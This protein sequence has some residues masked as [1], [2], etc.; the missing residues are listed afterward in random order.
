[1][2]GKRRRI[3]C[4]VEVRQVE[5]DA[6]MLRLRHLRGDGARDV[7]ARGEL[8]QGVIIGHEPQAGP[9]AEIGPLAPERLGQEVAGRAGDVEHR[10]VELH[11]FHVAELGPG[12]VGQR[13]AVGGGDRRVRGFA[14]EVP[15]PAGRE[16]DGARPDQR[17][18]PAPVPDQGAPAS[19][20][21]RE[22][23]DREAVLPDPGIGPGAGLLDH[24]AHHLAAGGVAQGV[25]DPGVRVPPFER[26][27]DLAVHLI[28]VRPPLD[29]LGDPP[30]R[31]ADDHGDDLGV[32]EP[33]ARRDRVG[34]VVVEGVLGIEH[35]RDP[36]LG[37]GAVA[38]PDLVLGDD[39]DPVRLGDPE[40]RAEA[41]EPSAD[42]ED[43]GEVVRQLTRVEA[44]QTASRR[45]EGDEH[46]CRRSSARGWGRA[47]RRP[48]PNRSGLFSTPTDRGSQRPPEPDAGA[49]LAG[50]IA[51]ERNRL[52]L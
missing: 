49:G 37:V 20:L 16:D 36:P 12:A 18:A 21:V 17:R 43:V 50:W 35:A 48:A 13:V 34:D 30:R 15:R 44:H 7:V 27:R 42:D 33:L 23:V 25:D 52:L 46:E 32:A 39:Q 8:G 2:P 1:M 10:R 26:Q 11:E 41:R 40:R 6:G 31:L 51:G 22:Q 28:E 9:I 3:N 47:S 19:S 38:L 4:R 24:G 29:Q 5:V 45:G 14:V